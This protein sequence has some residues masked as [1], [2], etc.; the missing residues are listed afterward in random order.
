MMAVIKVDGQADPCVIKWV[1]RKGLKVK[2]ITHCGETVD[3][4]DGVHQVPDAAE[5]C[6]K[7]NTALRNLMKR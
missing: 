1:G 6:S 3:A 2:A 7:C 4:G 5:T